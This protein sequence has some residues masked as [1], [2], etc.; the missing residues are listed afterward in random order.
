[1]TANFQ[2]SDLVYNR[3]TKEDG[4]IRRAYETSGAAMYE[5]AVPR[6]GHSWAAGYYISDWAEDV[7]QPSANAPLKSSS[8]EGAICL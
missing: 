3:N 2:L 8:L 4:A 5:V 7:L 6:N 1:M